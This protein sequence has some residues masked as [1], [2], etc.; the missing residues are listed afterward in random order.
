MVTSLSIG[1]IQQIFGLNTS[2]EQSMYSRIISKC[3]P[4]AGE[5]AQEA[6]VL[7]S[8]AQ[9]PEFDPQNPG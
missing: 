2:P 8:E 4:R 6:K 7:A 1:I 9:Q 5:A 3:V